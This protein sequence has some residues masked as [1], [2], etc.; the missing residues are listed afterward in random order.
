MSTIKENKIENYFMKTLRSYLDKVKVTD[1]DKMSLFWASSTEQEIQQ[2]LIDLG[3][4]CMREGTVIPS[5]ISKYIV[6]IF[7]KL[8]YLSTNTI[9]EHMPDKFKNIEMKQRRQGKTFESFGKETKITKKLKKIAGEK[10]EKM[11]HDLLKSE[12]EKIELELKFL[13]DKL[14]QT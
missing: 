6:E 9:R 11:E 8:G 7:N 3:E 4:S 5:E 10:Y 14:N 13:K 1:G 2:F 12:K